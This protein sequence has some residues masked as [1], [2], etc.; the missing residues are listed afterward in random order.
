M[1]KSLYFLLSLFS[2]QSLHSQISGNCNAPYNT[3][4]S[5]V[6]ILVGEGVEYSNVTFSGFDCSAGY[7]DGTSN[8]DFQTGLVLATN[9]VESITPGGFGVGGG[10]AGT[11]ADLEEQLQIVNATNTDLNNLIVLEFDFIPNSDAV[12]FNYI[13]ASN[14]YQSFTC[15]DFNDI[16]GFFLSGPGINGPFSNN[17]EN[18]ALVPDPSDPTQYTNTPV[19]INSVNSGFAS[20]AGNEYYCDDIDP[21]WQD[22]S[23]FLL[24]MKV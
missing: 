4:E 24:K 17:A 2:V 13:F 14:E 9:G 12:T 10:G 15:N 19:I 6:E 8:L 22:Y 16:F 23:V 3:P 11:D 1:N 20:T 18:I 5:L 7:F 21:N